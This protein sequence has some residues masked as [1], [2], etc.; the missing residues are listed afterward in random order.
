MNRLAHLTA[1]ALG[2][3]LC[4]VPAPE[5]LGQ[6]ITVDVGRGPVAVNVP[7]SYDPDVAMPLIVGLH[8]YTSSGEGLNS[9]FGLTPLSDEKGF[10]LVTPTGLA[11]A[12]GSPYW[13]A[14]NA[15]CDFETFSTDDSGYLRDLIEAIQD[16][17]SI[18][19]KRVYVTGHSN[20]GFMSYRMACDHADLVAAIA[21][22]AGATWLDP[23]ECNP[24]EPVS[25]LHMHG[26][27]DPVIL[28]DGGAT[29]EEGV[30]PGAEAS[31]DTWAGYNGCTSSRRI[32]GTADYVSRARGS[33]TQVFS[34]GRGCPEGGQI[35]LWKINRAIHSPGF[36]DAW[37]DD[38]VDWLLAHPKP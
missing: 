8:G 16:E 30:Y 15:C 34:H 9:Y 5:A 4:I 25:V 3:A 37:N 22:L 13:N 36:T 27:A 29:Y 28:Y 24:S 10:I 12:D 31:V 21:P 35:E 38:M 20:G 7:P 26:T 18:D 33:E 1:T 14:T 2:L 6:D 19:E 32:A 11:N 17:L 23:A